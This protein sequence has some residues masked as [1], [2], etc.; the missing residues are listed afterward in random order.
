MKTFEYCGT[1]KWLF[2]SCKIATYHGSLPSKEP[3]QL[4]SLPDLG[5]E[6]KKNSESYC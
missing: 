1:K 2:R 6:S 3:L 4:N 5:I